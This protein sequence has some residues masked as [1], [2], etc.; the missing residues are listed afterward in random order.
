M[1]VYLSMLNLVGTGKRD[2]EIYARGYAHILET[3]HELALKIVR[4]GE[5]DGEMSSTD[6]CLCCSRDTGPGCSSSA[7]F[8]MVLLLCQY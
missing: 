8:R 2:G 3:C 5:R 1:A 4:R 6:P 7:R